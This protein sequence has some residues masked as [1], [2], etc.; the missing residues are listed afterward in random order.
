MTT[1]TLKIKLNVTP[2]QSAA[3]LETVCKF[4]ESFNRVSKIGW[5]QKRINGVE[6]HKASYAGEKAVSS[7]PSQLIISSRMKATEALKAVRARIKKGRKGSLPQSKKCPIRYDARS[8][9]IKLAEGTASLLTLNRREKVTFSLPEYYASKKDWKVC[10]SDLCIDKHGKI[11][12]HVVVENAAPK[13]QASGRVV[14]VDL[15]VNR[16]AVT[17]DNKFF[18]TR[19]W[20][21][22]ENRNF[23]LKR[24]LQAKGTKSAKRHLVKLSRKV[25]RF[26]NDCDHVISK[27]IVDSAPIGSVI[28]IE[29]LTDIRDRVK[30][31]KKVRRRIHA[32]SFSRLKTYLVYKAEQQAIVVNFGDPRYTSQKCSSCGY[33]AKSNRKTQSFFCCSECRFS[34]NADLN[35]AKNIRNNYLASFGINGSASELSGLP[36]N[37][38]IVANPAMASVTSSRL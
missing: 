15:G 19:Y 36:V 20:K 23:R 11:F 1:I 10:S 14:G 22:I 7:L 21:E 3:F 8:A 5:G 18:G 4:T 6:L 17:S 2:E 33:T 26:R 13:F 12:L 37:Q 28:A 38:P 35:A 34:H 31:R 32:W 29:D 9:T 16:P 27:R 30:A 24:V 25:N